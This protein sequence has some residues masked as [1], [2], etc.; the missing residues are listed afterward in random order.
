MHF[1]FIVED[2]SG[3]IA[4]ETIVEKII[5]Q[6]SFEHSYRII[7]YKGAGHIPKGIKPKNTKLYCK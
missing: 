5:G 1:E 4:L 3:K 7:A 6:N 2:A